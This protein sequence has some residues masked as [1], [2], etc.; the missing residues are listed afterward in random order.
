[1]MD[2]FAG[3]LL[4]NWSCQKRLH[5]SVTNAGMEKIFEAAQESGALGGKAFGAVGCGCI[6]CY[7]RPERQHQVRKAIQAEGAKI[8]DFNID[9]FGA[10]SWSANMEA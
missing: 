10:E 7:C 1:H 5:P 2:A 3:L 4:R 6:L 9:F 8:I